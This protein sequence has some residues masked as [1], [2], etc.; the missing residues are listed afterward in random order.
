M[1]A[2]SR[3]GAVVG[4]LA[5]GMVI[6][7][8]SGP[9]AAPPARTVASVPP[10]ASAAATTANTGG[11]PTAEQLCAAF[12]PALAV[13]ALGKPADAPSS[14]AVLPR[15]NGVYCAYQATGDR[16]TRVDAQLKSMTRAEFETL[17]ETLSITT[18]LPGVGEVAFIRDGSFMGVAGATVL[19]WSAG[20]GVTVDLHREGSQSEMDAAAAAIASAALAST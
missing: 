17:S 6:G 2:G 15:P 4:A 5:L 18:P 16:N 9:P 14:G 10:A 13:A 8:S 3:F 20:R 19:A 1:I 12:I 7:C 11:E